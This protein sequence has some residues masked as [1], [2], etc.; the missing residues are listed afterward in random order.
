MTTRAIVRA[1]MIAAAYWIVTVALAPISYGP[2]QLRLSGLLYPLALFAPE[3]AVGFGVGVFLANLNSPF[4]LLDM[5]VMPLA[6]AAACAL[7]YRLRNWPVF[8]L[9]LHAAITA[10]CVSVFPL[11]IGA[12]LPVLMTLPGILA[13]QLIVVFSGWL[14]IWRNR[15]RISALTGAGGG[16]AE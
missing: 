10:A 7:A 12:G 8:A 3:Y 16:N 9:A 13:S 14:I 15:A 4:G 5:A 2:V 1:G 11:G 6:T